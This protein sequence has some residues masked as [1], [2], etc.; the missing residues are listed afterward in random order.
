MFDLSNVLG[1]LGAANCGQT[2]VDELRRIIL[3]SSH[4]TQEEVTHSSEGTRDSSK[5]YRL[6]AASRR[7]HEQLDRLDGH[8]HHLDIQLCSMRYMLDHKKDREHTK[9]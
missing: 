7:L 2:N 3:S 1:G 6:T 5:I 8:R 4:R 9:P